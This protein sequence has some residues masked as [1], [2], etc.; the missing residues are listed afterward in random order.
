MQLSAVRYHGL[1]TVIDVGKSSLAEIP[2]SVPAGCAFRNL[3]VERVSYSLVGNARIAGHL[4]QR[5]PSEGRRG[6]DRD[7]STDQSVHRARAAA[8][9]AA[10]A[11]GCRRCS[12]VCTETG[13]RAAE[14]DRRRDHRRIR[15]ECRCSIGGIHA[16][17]AGVEFSIGGDGHRRFLLRVHGHSG[18]SSPGACTRIGRPSGQ[19]CRRRS[20]QSAHPLPL[21]SAA[22]QLRPRH[23]P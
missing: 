15:R 9:W 3:R 14:T 21:P 8:V 5:R 4:A 23:E 10:S 16:G 13:D 19:R 6:N 22:T 2:L 12:V 7:R 20:L 1:W 17:P 11:S 18:R